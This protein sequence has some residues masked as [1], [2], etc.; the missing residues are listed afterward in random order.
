[1]GVREW[2]GGLCFV[3]R[4]INI[5]YV[6]NIRVMLRMLLW[7]RHNLGWLCIYSTFRPGC[8]DPLGTMQLL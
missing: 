5:C 3:G 6:V 1:M 8:T 7:E 4:L 2:N